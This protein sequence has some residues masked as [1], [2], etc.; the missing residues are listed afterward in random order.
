MIHLLPTGTPDLI[1]AERDALVRLRELLERVGDE[2]ERVG[3]VDSLLA[4]L[5]EL[6]LVVLVGE[7]NSGKSTVLNALFG[8]KLMEEGPIPTTNQITILRHGEKMERQKSESVVERR[9]PSDI[10]RYVHMVDTPGTNS[11]IQKHQTITEDF[12]PRADLVLFVTSYD[13]PLTES[14]RKFLTYIRYTWGKEL[15]FIV[16]KAD[17]ARDPESLEQV[18]EHIRS[19]CRELMDFEPDIYPVSAELAYSAKVSDTESVSQTLWERSNFEPLESLITQ[20]LA[21]PERLS[22]KLVSPL[23]TAR[24]VLE[25]LSDNLAHRKEVVE[26]DEENILALEEQLTASERPLKRGYRRQLAEIDALLYQLERR[27]IQF[28][29]DTL[30]V[31]RLKLLRDRDQYKQEFNRQ[32]VR[33]TERQIESLV[34]DAVDR[35]TESALELWNTTLRSFTDRVREAEGERPRPDAE[36]YPYNRAETFRTIMKEAERR[37]SIYDVE[38]EARRTLENARSSADLM[39]YTEAGAAGLGVLGIALIAATGLDVLG[40]VGL[41]TAGVLSVAGFAL[42][43]R[44]KRK[45]SR[46]LRREVES[47]REEMKQALSWQFDQEVRNVLERIRETTAPYRTFVKQERALLEESTAAHRELVDEV[48]HLRESVDSRRHNAASGAA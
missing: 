15:V 48:E 28:F 20:T 19:G 22:R 43:P 27:G 44:H 11:I 24:A 9:Y 8:E 18:L 23:N 7:F 47:L 30:R 21:G 46:A 37:I 16:N 29:D 38:Q 4:Q 34:T 17:I 1:D 40:G 26:Q 6:F 14:E 3:Q 45:A 10:L 12:I 39:Q 35:L 32:V 41:A 31:S 13:R 33:D 36:A 25:S 2:S 42:L 5:D